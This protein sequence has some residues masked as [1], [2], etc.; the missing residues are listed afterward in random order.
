MDL[1]PWRHAEAVDGVPD[2]TRELTER[3]IRQAWAAA[4]RYG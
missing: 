4:A 1:P 3:G 2:S